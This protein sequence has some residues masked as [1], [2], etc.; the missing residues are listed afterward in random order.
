MRWL[1]E[2]ARWRQ[3]KIKIYSIQYTIAQLR[4][5][6]IQATKISNLYVFSAYVI[7]EKR[8]CRVVSYRIV[9]YVTYVN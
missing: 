1:K 5:S 2:I 4:A 3:S 6:I 8:C 7:R 9:S